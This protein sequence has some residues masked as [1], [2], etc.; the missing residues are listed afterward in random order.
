MEYV[1]ALFS[2][3]FEPQ[4]RIRRNVNQIEDFL[5]EYYGMPQT[6][7]I[8]DE[9]AAEAPRVVLN[10]KN[11]HSQI[12]F[13]QI[14]VDLTV[15][16]DGEYRKDFELTKN[17]I[18]QRVNKLKD[19]LKIID[20][21]TFYFA[22]ISYNVRLD[23]GSKT[24]SQY[25]AELLNTEITD[26]NIYEASKRIAVV[27]DDAFFVNEQLGTFKEYQ[28][29][30][31]SIPNL[32]DFKNSRLVSEGVNLVVDVNNRYEYLFNGLSKPLDDYDCIITKI[33]EIIERNLAK[34]R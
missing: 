25:M 6:M 16:F 27:E 29:K 34:W 3:K 18:L 9:F 14:S 11:G 24:P 20:I 31:N 15:N 17:Y 32:L 19:L 13:S 12:S 7:P 4:I 33:Y 28:G 30:G 10:S 5:E 23:T 2:L 8:P 26:T 22:G 21:T 1:Q